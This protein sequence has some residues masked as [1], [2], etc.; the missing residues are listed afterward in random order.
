MLVCCGVGGCKGLEP[1][2][3][4]Q[5]RLSRLP[6]VAGEAQARLTLERKHA[7]SEHT[8]TWTRPGQ[9]TAPAHTAAPPHAHRKRRHPRGR[10]KKDR[11]RGRA[12]ADGGDVVVRKNTLRQQLRHLATRQRRNARLTRRLPSAQQHARRSAEATR[13]RVPQRMNSR[14]YVN[15]CKAVTHLLST[16][17]SP[18]TVPPTPPPSAAK[19]RAMSRH[20][21]PQ[22]SSSSPTQVKREDAR[23]DTNTGPLKPPLHARA[24]PH[25]ARPISSAPAAAAAGAAAPAATGPALLQRARLF[26]PETPANT[27]L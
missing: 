24:H 10:K 22:R 14:R 3:S 9:T 2:H 25:R 26:P 16:L 19:W 15:R 17:A 21:Y 23:R 1:H 12:D 11:G 8:A 27:L 20:T 7:L 6:V 5:R 18:R 13:C 4:I